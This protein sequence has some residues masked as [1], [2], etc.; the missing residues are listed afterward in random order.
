MALVIKQKN[1]LQLLLNFYNKLNFM[2]KLYF[3]FAFYKIDWKTETQ[4]LKMNKIVS[5]NNDIC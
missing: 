2:F 4:K 3:E 1:P 5:Y